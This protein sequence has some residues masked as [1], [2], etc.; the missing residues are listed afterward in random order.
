[1]GRPAQPQLPLG[2]GMG[3]STWQRS[4]EAEAK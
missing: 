4:L 2:L 1:M 3:V